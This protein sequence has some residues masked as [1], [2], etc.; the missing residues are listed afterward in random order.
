VC[1]IASWLADDGVSRNPILSD[2][3]MAT[4]KLAEYTPGHSFAYEVTGFT[5]FVLRRLAY[6]VR[7]EWTFTPDGSGTVI[8]WTYEFKPLR[9]RYWLI[10]HVLAPLWRHY[11]QPVLKQPRVWPRPVNRDGLSLQD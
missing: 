5:N 10:R 1:Q 11:M 7:G 8:R 6:G 9:R 4:E 3:S 2:G